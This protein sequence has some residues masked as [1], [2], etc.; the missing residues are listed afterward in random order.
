MY[1]N[2]LQVVI[3]LLRPIQTE[4]KRKLK[5]KLS[6]MFVI[7]NRPQRCCGKVIFLHLS[8][9]LFAGGVHTHPQVDTPGTPL[10]QC[11][12]GYGQ[13]TSGTHLTGMH[14]CSLIFFAC[15]LIFFA[16]SLILFAFAPLFTWCE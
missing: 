10:S 11:M 12:L 5:R 13:Q 7:Y 15:S 14:S 9:I 2:C 8:V 3:S 16:C 6:L 4:R 1:E